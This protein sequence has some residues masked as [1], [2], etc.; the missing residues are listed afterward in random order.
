MTVSASFGLK[1]KSGPKT[2][3]FP[4]PWIS[5]SV[6]RKETKDRPRSCRTRPTKSREEKSWS[7]KSEPFGPGRIT[8]PPPRSSAT[9]AVQ[10]VAPSFPVPRSPQR[11]EVIDRV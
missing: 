11:G 2:R 10:L 3:L 7:A 8:L 4:P 9:R 1:R 6:T 5:L